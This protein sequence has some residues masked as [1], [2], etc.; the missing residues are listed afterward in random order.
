MGVIFVKNSGQQFGNLSSIEIDDRLRSKGLMRQELTG[1]ARKTALMGIVQ[2]QLKNINRSDVYDFLK[3]GKTN[4]L[5]INHLL[6]DQMGDVDPIIFRN[7]L[8]TAIDV[9]A[10]LKKNAIQ[11]GAKQW[12]DEMLGPT[13]TGDPKID[14][15]TI[16]VKAIEAQTNTEAWEFFLNKNLRERL[17]RPE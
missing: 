6:E 15:M 1:D 17:R 3:G 7:D 11:W 2:E 14:S 16:C 12:C 8:R 5:L 9:N 4:D 10:E 13:A